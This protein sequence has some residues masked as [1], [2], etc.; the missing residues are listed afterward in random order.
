MHCFAVE[1]ALVFNLNADHNVS[2]IKNLGGF[3][4]VLVDVQNEANACCL[5][6][7]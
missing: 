7:E 6:S 5:E 3:K 1:V 2:I 4:A